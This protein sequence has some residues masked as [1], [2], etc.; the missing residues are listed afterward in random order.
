M[1]QSFYWGG[2][3]AYGTLRIAAI[4]IPVRYD[5]FYDSRPYMA[6]LYSE[7]DYVRDN[8]SPA[9]TEW[10]LR[11][12]DGTPADF[13]TRL[14]Q[15]SARFNVGNHYISA[16]RSFADIRE[17]FIL[18]E[19]NQIRNR[20]FIMGFLLVNIFLGVVGTF[21]YR[22]QQ[23]RGDLGL[24]MAMGASRRSL[25]RSLMTEGI[26][27]LVLATIPAFV[28]C[29]NIG[30]FDITGSQFIYRMRLERG[31]FGI[32]IAITFVLMLLMIIG[33]IA[34][35]AHRAM[36]IQPAEALHDE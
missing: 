6:S 9:T 7:A 15:E 30:I 29:Y 1:E 32:E 25:Y 21:W 11:V 28:V 27:L 12:K 23:R 35:P 17:E 31:D 10:C 3:S 16:V 14:L 18:E 19:L 5:D 34:Y 26:I 8:D 36:H 24:R 2:D 33:A 22:T 13:G 20:A 4:T